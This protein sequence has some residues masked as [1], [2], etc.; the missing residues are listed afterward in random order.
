[1]KAGQF[2]ARLRGLP[3][4]CKDEHCFLDEEISPSLTIDDIWGKLSKYWSFLNYTLLESLINLL[5]FHDLIKEMVSFLQSLESF[6]QKTHL[7]D[8][9]KCCRAWREKCCEDFFMIHLELNWETCTLE[10]LHRLHGHILRKFHLPSFSMTLEEIKNGCLIITWSI[11]SEL[12]THVKEMLRGPDMLT[13]FK[14]Q[15]ILSISIDCKETSYSA[16][17]DGSG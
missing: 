4:D 17:L 15:R 5:E 16:S 2:K 13:F 8:F 3:I 12:A 6:R 7:C 11:L 10:D 14:E 1:M 9:A